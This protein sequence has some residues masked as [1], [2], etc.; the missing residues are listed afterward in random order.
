MA[1]SNS[2]TTTVIANHPSVDPATLLNIINGTIDQDAQV[3]VSTIPGSSPNLSTYVLLGELGLAAIN[4]IVQQ[5]KA[6]K[7]A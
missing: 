1:A 2:P 4:S 6:A 3:I 7:S 5:I